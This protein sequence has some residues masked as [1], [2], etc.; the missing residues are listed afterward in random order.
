MVTTATTVTSTIRKTAE[1]H[2]IYS[3]TTEHNPPEAN[4]RCGMGN[5]KPKNGY[6]H[7][8]KH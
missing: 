2:V 5:G 3:T 7:S 6:Y 4:Y 1:L 8:N